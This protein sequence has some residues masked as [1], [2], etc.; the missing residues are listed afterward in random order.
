MNWLQKLVFGSKAE[1]LG[2][3][4]GDV[5]QHAANVVGQAQDHKQAMTAVLAHAGQEVAAADSVI[6]TL[7]KFTQ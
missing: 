7:S 1:V 3:K 4:V 6:Q 5:F 2:H